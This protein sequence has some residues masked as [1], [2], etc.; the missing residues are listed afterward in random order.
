[1]TVPSSWQDAAKGTMLEIRQAM[2]GRSLASC[3]LGFM[4]SKNGS[5]EDWQQQE[6][7]EFNTRSNNNKRY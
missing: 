6:Q 1:M 3:G 7:H 4:E 5:F 2:F